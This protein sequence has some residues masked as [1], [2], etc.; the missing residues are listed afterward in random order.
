[1][2]TNLEK[3][4]K[5][6]IKEIPE[7]VEL[8]FGCFVRYGEKYEG[9]AVFEN[10]ISRTE[11]TI[12]VLDLIFGQQKELKHKW[13]K[14]I[15]RKITLADILRVLS[16]GDKKELMIEDSWGVDVGSY[17]VAGLLNLWNLSKND[18]NLQ[19]EKTIAF[20]TNI[21]LKEDE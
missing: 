9:L 16:K 6:I 12:R 19:S 10:W 17:V 15:G 11:K 4:K 14:I 3:L 18:L 21:I 5:A 20:L 8:K 2:K 7:I 1:M 13:I